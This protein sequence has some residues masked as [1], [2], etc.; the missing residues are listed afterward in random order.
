MILKILKLL[1]LIS[2]ICILGQG[3]SIA[4]TVTIDLSN[5]IGPIT[6][7]AS[8]FL[9]SISPSTP[10][11]ALVDTL[12]PKAFRLRE[13]PNNYTG[14]AFITYHRIKHLGAI[15]QLNI[16][17]GFGY[18]GTN[19]W[20]GEAGVWNVWENYI[21]DLVTR[22][23]DK[24]YEVQWDIWNEPDILSFWNP[25][26]DKKAR[27]FETWLRAVVIIRSLDQDSI[28]IG[29]S[30]AYFDGTT[31]YFSVEEFLTYAKANNVLPD[32]LSWHTWNYTAIEN[33][34]T[35]IRTFMTNNGIEQIPISINE[36]VHDTEKTNPG[37]LPWYFAIFEKMQIASA[38]HACWYDQDG[39]T[40]QCF[41]A[42]LNGI[43]TPDTRQPRSAWWVYKGYADI[44]GNLVQL[45]PSVN[46]N[47]IAGIDA[48]KKYA[49]ILLGRKGGVASI[50]LDISNL[51]QCAFLIDSNNKVRVRA[52]L[53]PNNGWNSLSQPSLAINSDY[54]VTN[55]QISISLPSFASGTAYVV[56]L[57]NPTSNCGYPGVIYPTGDINLD[58]KVDLSD[59]TIIAGKWLSCY[60]PEIKD[61]K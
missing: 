31:S 44:T 24:N 59:F 19:G 57:L 28:I 33:D 53:I 1:L 10:G 14:G 38:C 41:N 23:L 61:C 13:L 34:I 49:R 27:F 48:G 12:K 20:P 56:S 60:D 52:E 2:F 45:Q 11:V 37:I 32:I 35:Q 17:D 18:G 15:L 46:V 29:P 6:Y 55:G 25:S 40:S 26:G 5:E 3:Q 9:H 51:D 16:S 36:Y 22:T 7:C 58:C 4:E 39:S 54:T 8:G 47:G 42:T 50:S 30:T 43:L 21:T